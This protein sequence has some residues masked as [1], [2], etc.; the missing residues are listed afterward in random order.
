MIARQIRTGLL[1]CRRTVPSKGR[2]LVL[3]ALASLVFSVSG[4]SDQTAHMEVDKEE[5]RTEFHE[6]ENE[7]LET[8]DPA[9]IPSVDSEQAGVPEQ[10]VPE[11]L[12]DEVNESEMIVTEEK[13]PAVRGVYVSTA[14]QKLDELES[15]VRSVSGD[16]DTAER[17]ELETRIGRLRQELQMLNQAERDGWIEEQRRFDSAL[18]QLEERVY[19]HTGGPGPGQA[20]AEGVG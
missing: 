5:G 4:C 14:E 2:L 10:Q 16:L 20:T 19:D 7:N 9:G 18:A 1:A 3:S 11:D 12:A 8:G 17:V 13:F 6:L 15:R